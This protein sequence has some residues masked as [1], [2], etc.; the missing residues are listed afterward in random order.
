MRLTSEFMDEYAEVWHDEA[1]AP[2]A[3]EGRAI[4]VTVAVVLIED[5]ELRVDPLELF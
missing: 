4:I 2:D 1:S 5:G 3:H